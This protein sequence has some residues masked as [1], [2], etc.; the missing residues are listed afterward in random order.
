MIIYGIPL[1]MNAVI[2]SNLPL[3]EIEEVAVR[4]FSTLPNRNITKPTFFSN[5]YPTESKLVP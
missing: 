5:P 4:E 1:Q 2:L 3:Q